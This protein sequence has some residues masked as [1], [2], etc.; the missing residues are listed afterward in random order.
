MGR[1][2]NDCRSYTVRTG[3][4]YEKKEGNK[5]VITEIWRSI[6]RENTIEGIFTFTKHIL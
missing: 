6:E 1:N 5:E 3:V 2:S 4:K